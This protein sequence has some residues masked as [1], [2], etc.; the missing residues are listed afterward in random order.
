MD[1]IE[2]NILKIIKEDKEVIEEIS[3]VD[4]ISNVTSSVAGNIKD[5]TSNKIEGF[6]NNEKVKSILT[7]LITNLITKNPDVLKRVTNN[8][9]DSI[10]INVEKK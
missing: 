3:I 1:N 6:F 9:L 2:N 10:K 7:D 8:V 5:I 4:V